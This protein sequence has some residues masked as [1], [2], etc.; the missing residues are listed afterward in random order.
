MEII[1]L[2]N[3]LESNYQIAPAAPRPLNGSSRPKQ[4]NFSF[5]KFRLYYLVYSGLPAHSDSD[6]MAKKCHCKVVSLYSMIFS[7]MRSFFGPK[8]CHSS[9][10]VTLTGVTESGE[11]K[12]VFGHFSVIQFPPHS[13]PDRQEQGKVKLESCRLGIWEWEP[14]NFLG[15]RIFEKFNLSL[16]VLVHACLSAPKNFALKT[17]T[18]KIFPASLRGSSTP[19]RCNL[20][21]S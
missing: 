5:Q 9:R 13:T 2:V 17:E 14:R 20:E 19:E 21:V 8:N 7:I 12:A 18:W 11:A 6:G 16:L 15:N 4:N 1:Q 3:D 10:S